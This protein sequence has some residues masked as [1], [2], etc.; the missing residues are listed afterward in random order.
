MPLD[1]MGL[2]DEGQDFMS[3]LLNENH[4]VYTLNHKPRSHM[5]EMEGPLGYRIKLPHCGRLVK[6]GS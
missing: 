6:Q 1:Y 3:L 4:R 5:G 2:S